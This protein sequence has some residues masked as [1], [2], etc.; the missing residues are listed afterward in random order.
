MFIV[1]SKSLLPVLAWFGPKQTYGSLRQATLHDRP[2][3]SRGHWD[4]GYSGTAPTARNRERWRRLWRECPSSYS[5]QFGSVESLHCKSVDANR[6]VSF[7]L[8]L[9]CHVQKWHCWCST[10]QW[11]L[12]LCHSWHKEVHSP[13]SQQADLKALV[14]VGSTLGLLPSQVRKVHDAGNGEQHQ[15]HQRSWKCCAHFSTLWN[16]QGKMV[17]VMWSSL[18]QDWFIW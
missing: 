11:Q 10:C 6:D 4:V 9:A 15:N 3:R 18:M 12:S 13:P 16:V 2:V 14:G 1:R 5:L 8:I 7:T 17:Q